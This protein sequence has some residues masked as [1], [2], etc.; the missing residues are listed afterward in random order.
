MAQARIVTANN[1]V[2]CRTL[3]VKAAKPTATC[4]QR[5][6]SASLQRPSA[7]LHTSV[8]GL[9]RGAKSLAPFRQQSDQI[10]VLDS[11]QPQASTSSVLFR[12]LPS[13][14][15]QALLFLAMS[16]GL[17]ATTDV[18]QAADLNFLA[19]LSINKGQVISFLVNNPFVT[20]G[21]AVSLYLIVPGVLRLATRYVLLPLTV[22]G[23][24]YL[25]ITNP[26]TSWRVVST[27][28]GCASSH[29]CLSLTHHAM[30]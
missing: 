1:I 28:F 14:Q 6:I 17:L 21:V 16:S 19:D 18:T 3:A 2:C 10:E 29:T 30:L 5:Q 7:Q 20:L 12:G 4:H 26:S 27:A 15:R 24:V 9:G 23:G 25:V 8:P 22:A 13:E 11:E